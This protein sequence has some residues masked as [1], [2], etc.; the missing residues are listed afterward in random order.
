MT[1]PVP[2]GDPL[3]RPLWEAAERHELLLQRCTACGHHQHYP[4][5]F[6][7]A[8]SREVEWVVASG[9]GSVYS[10]TTV[11]LPMT[12]HAEPPYDVVLVTLDEGPRLTLLAT[13]PGLAIGTRVRVAWLH[14][15]DGPPL[16]VAEAW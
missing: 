14:R 16:P 3:S 4:R 9:G 7:L 15:D 12:P 10:A 11:H 6:C 5:P 13:G 8:C 1:D 2:Y